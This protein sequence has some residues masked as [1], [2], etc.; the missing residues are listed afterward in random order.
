MTKNLQQRVRVANPSFVL[1]ALSRHLL[2]PNVV[3]RMIENAVFYALLSKKS[4]CAKNA[5]VLMGNIAAI[6]AA[7]TPRP[8]APTLWGRR[9]V[10]HS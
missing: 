1:P 6:T 5:P 10:T 2:L 3:R 8:P 7:T 9:P 4:T